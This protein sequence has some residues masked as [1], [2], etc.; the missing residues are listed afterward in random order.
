M[1][2]S[3]RKL[4]VPMTRGRRALLPRALA[5][6]LALLPLAAVHDAPGAPLARGQ[7]GLTS[8]SESQQ[9]LTFDAGGTRLAGTL[10]VPRG[11]T[12]CATVIVLHGASSPSRALPLYR[13]LQ[14]MLPPLGIAVFVF[15]RR[16]GGND[17]YN[18][19]VLAADAV[20]ARAMLAQSPRVD[21]ARIGYWGVSQGGWLALLA[22]AKD[23]HAAFVIAVSAPLT[24]PAVQMNFAVANILAIK[25]F[26]SA[27]I[28]AA[29]GAR[30]AVDD[31]LRGD[32]GRAPAQR[33]LDA[34]RQQP[35]FSLI[36][37][38]SNLPDRS[39]SAWAQQMRFDPLPL[40]D[41]LQAPT[42]L[43]YGGADPWVPVRESLQRLA[44]IEPRHAN[45]RSSVVAGADHTM[46]LA[47]SPQDQ[48][49][50]KFFPKEAPDAPAYFAVLA[51]W[52]TQQGFAR[53]V[54]R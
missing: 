43:I 30:Q 44:S 7:A 2:R 22:A 52:L 25:G 21:G 28:R 45:L 8:A 15:D 37:T 31:Y 18:F 41:R 49:D 13:H 1:Q 54:E 12:R 42:L 17:K 47:V 26:S 24:T 38:D 33:I 36:Y 46:M 48:V 32:L 3:Q 16:S 9:E 50:P 35:W 14:E 34:A 27:D 11:A 5:A 6:L 10:Y 51:A 39:S 53:P 40:L 4:V 19:E 23:V 29:V 20:A